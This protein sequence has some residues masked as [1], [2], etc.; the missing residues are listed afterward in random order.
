MGK[1]NAVTILDKMSVNDKERFWSKVDI[2]SE[3]ECWTWKDG[4]QKNGY[5]YLSVGGRS[6]KNIPA[7]RIAKTLSIGEEIPDG[8][9]V[10]H[11]CDNP[12]CCNPGHLECGTQTD[13]I[14]DMVN[15]GRS[16]T[17]FSCAKLDWDIVDT[18]R[19]S[20]L[21]GKEL[22]EQ[23]SIPAPTI[24][25]IRNHRTWKEEHRETAKIPMDVDVYE[26][27]IDNDCIRMI[28]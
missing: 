2:K 8:L 21:T 12:P 10:M 15:K 7:H 11:S 5:G 6:G 24:S 25:K 28:I 16:A 17:S 26:L 18:I 14:K 9:V 23:L 19:Q 4:L 20:S 1:K 3:E 27:Q 13:N 22:S